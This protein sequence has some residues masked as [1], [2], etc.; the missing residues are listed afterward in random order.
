MVPTCLFHGDGLFAQVT[1][2]VIPYPDVQDRYFTG[3]VKALSFAEHRIAGPANHKL[4]QTNGTN[5]HAAISQSRSTSRR[6]FPGPL[7]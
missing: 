1:N 5:R 7:P 2:A 4:C 6:D 3:F